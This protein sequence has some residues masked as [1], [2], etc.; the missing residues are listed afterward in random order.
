M[1]I[2]IEI[3][4]SVAGALLAGL[5]A[6]E[7]KGWAPRICHRL[8]D[9]AVRRLPA[10]YRT[11]YREEWLAHLDELPTVLSRLMVAIGFGLAAERIHWCERR[12]VRRA[13]RHGRRNDAAGSLARRITRLVQFDRD[14]R[15][16]F[17]DAYARRVDRH[18][19]AEARKWLWLQITLRIVAGISVMLG[20]TLYS[21]EESPDS[22]RKPPG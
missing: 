11:R 9:R 8:V 15:A 2:I 22:R 21:A 16:N 5:I 20:L 17:V 1:S 14:F 18:G 12:H 6:V 4:A 10:K 7:A 3:G 13:Q 19:R